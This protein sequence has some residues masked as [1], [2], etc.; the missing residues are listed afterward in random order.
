MSLIYCISP[1]KVKVHID[2]Y[3]GEFP[4]V[5]QLDKPL[6]AKKGKKVIHHFAHK[7]TGDRDSWGEIKMTPWHWSYQEICKP[8][9]IEI[10]IERDGVLHIADIRNNDGLVIELQHSPIDDEVIKARE[11]FY[12]DMI[13][14]FDYSTACSLPKGYIVYENNTVAVIRMRVEVK[15][16]TKPTFFDSGDKIYRFVETVEE[17]KMMDF[18]DSVFGGYRHESPGKGYCIFVKYTRKNFIATYFKDITCKEYVQPEFKKGFVIDNTKHRS[19]NHRFTDRDLYSG[20]KIIGSKFYLKPSKRADETDEDNEEDFEDVVS[21]LTFSKNLLIIDK[22]TNRSETIPQYL[23]RRKLIREE[24]RRLKEEA[25]LVKQRANIAKERAKQRTEKVEKEAKKRNETVVEYLAREK[26]E[27]K[28]D[29]ANKRAIRLEESVA[30]YTLLY[31]MFETDRYI[32]IYVGR[33]HVE[34]LNSDY[35]VNEGVTYE[36]LGESTKY[37]KKNDKRYIWCYKHMP[38]FI[39]PIQ[40]VPTYNVIR[41]TETVRCDL[42][43]GVSRYSTSRAF[44]EVNIYERVKAPAVL[45]DHFTKKKPLRHQQA[46]DIPPWCHLWSR[47]ID[48]WCHHWSRQI[49]PHG[50]LLEEGPIQILEWGIEYQKAIETLKQQVREQQVREQQVR[51]QQER[52]R[53][54]RQQQA[55]EKHIREQQTREAIEDPEGKQRQRLKSLSAIDRIMSHWCPGF[56]DE[57]LVVENGRLPYDEVISKCIWLE[58]VQE[59]RKQDEQRKLQNQLELEH[60]ERERQ[61]QQKQRDRRTRM[62]RLYIEVDNPLE[63]SDHT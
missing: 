9:N 54:E 11:E 2:D 19:Y 3:N 28:K 4:A 15:K 45:K 33:N 58:M 7:Y 17:T 29:L 51:E 48:P 62:N 42:Y 35:F 53:R 63:S 26:A 5:S 24:A 6:V 57:D 14:L 55:R 59:T 60:R 47:E 50:R 10:R 30:D 52:E 46:R 25:D 36:I 16:T 39:S 38:D 32:K 1:D 27:R 37:E 43:I 20:I 12:G 13:W 34:I 21:D 8:E 49:D 22:V 61:A 56:P 44:L 23:A 40:E 18:L 31:S 41:N